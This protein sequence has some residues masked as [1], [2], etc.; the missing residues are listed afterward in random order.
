MQWRFPQA[1]LLAVFFLVSCGNRANPGAETQQPP[2]PPFEFLGAWGDKGDG[3]GQ[4][5]R[6]RGVR[7][8]FAGQYFLR[9]SRPPDLSTNLNPAALPC[10]PLRIR[11]CATPRES[12][13][14]PAAR[15]MSL[16]P[17]RATSMF[18]SRWNI[19]SNLAER[20]PAPFFRCAGDRLRRRGHSLR[21]RSR[22]FRILK[23]NNHGRLVK[24]WPAP[25]KAISPDERPSWVSAQPDNFVFVAYFSTGR[26][27]KFSSDGSSITSWSAANA[28]SGESSPIAGIA[29][30]GEFCIYDGRF[31]L[32]DSRLDSGWT[33]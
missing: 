16:T 18:F 5:R 21:A 31:V 6:A 28:P 23:F 4:T 10:N 2:P 7:R 25:Q 9:R 22:E 20:R 17:N 14:M 11:V 19:F 24:S 13:W 12:R 29:A 26:M 3:P 8:R 30:A 32:G 33:A 15:F 27:E 1:A